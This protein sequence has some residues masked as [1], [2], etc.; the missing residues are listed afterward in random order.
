MYTTLAIY[1]TLL[2]KL[3]GVNNPEGNHLLKIEGI[4][5]IQGNIAIMVFNSEVGFPKDESKAIL[6]KVLP[7]NKKQMTIPLG[8]LPSGD[9]AISVIQDCLLYT[10][11]SPRD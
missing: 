7:V 11:P 10:S 1:L 3:G 4:K 8:N 2:F 9:Y 5:D 6:K